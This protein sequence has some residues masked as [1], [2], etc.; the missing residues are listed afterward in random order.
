MS[1]LPVSRCRSCGAY[2]VWAVDDT[3]GAKLPLDAR[4]VR[5][6][7]AET[8]ETGRVSAAP[9][10]EGGKPRLSFVSHFVTC[11]KPDRFS[12]RGRRDPRA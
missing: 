5:T 6:Y 9:L 1:D 7:D 4:C 3:T 2:I 8:T 10:L 11:R 12:G